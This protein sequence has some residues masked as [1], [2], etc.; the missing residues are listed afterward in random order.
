MNNETTKYYMTAEDYNEYF[1][2]KDIESTGIKDEEE[3][4]FIELEI[5]AIENKEDRLTE[6][7]IKWRNI[8]N[9]ENGEIKNINTSSYHALKACY[10]INEDEEEEEEEEESE[11][12]KEI[13][14]HGKTKLIYKNLLNI[15]LEENEKLK[16]E[17]IEKDKIINDLYEIIELNCSL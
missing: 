6:Y 5:Q 11:L 1:L 10:W 17:N 15:N 2:K 4:D 7:S 8:E 13:K 12:L 3:E 9:G 14:E 16:N